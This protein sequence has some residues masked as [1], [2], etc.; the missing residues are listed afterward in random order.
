MYGILIVIQCTRVIIIKRRDSSA[1][2]C[3]LYLTIFTGENH[4]PCCYCNKSNPCITHRWDPHFKQK[5][6]SF[7]WKPSFDITS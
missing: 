2:S 1:K 6:C 4:G 3:Q 5:F 7:L